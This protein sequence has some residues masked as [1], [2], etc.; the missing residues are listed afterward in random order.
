LI[1]IYVGQR[2]KES[3]GFGYLRQQFPTIIEAKMK[4]GIF[5]GPQ[6]KQPF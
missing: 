2:D 1:K 3:E 4:G 6:I 5:D